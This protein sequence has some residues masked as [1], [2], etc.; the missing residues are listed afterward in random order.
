MF[1]SS[2]KAIRIKEGMCTLATMYMCNIK[3]VIKIPNTSGLM[4]ILNQKQM[5]IKYLLPKHKIKISN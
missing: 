2:I 3:T 4:Y 1:I 5:E